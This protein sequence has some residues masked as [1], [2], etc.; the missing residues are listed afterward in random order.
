MTT[1]IKIAITIAVILIVT[2]V[3]IM[4]A[5]VIVKLARKIV[6]LIRNKI[7][8]LVAKPISIIS[9]A[10]KIRVAINPSFPIRITPI[11]ITK[12]ISSTLINI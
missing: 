10:L 5:V 11:K 4:T 2:K 7:R 6:K 8:H 1:T 12:F 9:T 3:I